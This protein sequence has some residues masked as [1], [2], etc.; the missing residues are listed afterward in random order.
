MGKMTNSIGHALE[1]LMSLHRDRNECIFKVLSQTQRCFSTSSSILLC[2]SSRQG[3]EA[4]HQTRG[5][6]LRGEFVYIF[7]SN[8]AEES[9]CNIFV[10][11]Y[12]LGDLRMSPHLWCILILFVC[13]CSE[14]MVVAKTRPARYVLAHF[15]WNVGTFLVQPELHVE[16]LYY[17]S[18][19]FICL[20]LLDYMK[21]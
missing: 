14:E 4:H 13:S 1:H 10:P 18:S 8:L 3:R 12:L 9:M 5:K 6:V 15:H 17:I 11:G 16:S 7:S 21:H 19:G 2:M 20:S